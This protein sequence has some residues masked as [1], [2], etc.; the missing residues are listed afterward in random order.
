MLTTLFCVSDP[1]ENGSS[2]D[3][4]EDLMLDITNPV[5]RVEH[6][7]S[8]EHEGTSPQDRD[9]FHGLWSNSSRYLSHTVYC[10]PALKLFYL[11]E[12]L[13]F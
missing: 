5:K 13:W 2:G 7:T 9:N 4:S 12:F 10:M 6:H 1:Y 11:S 3:N 8:S